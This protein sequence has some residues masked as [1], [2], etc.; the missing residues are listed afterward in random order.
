LLVAIAKSASYKSLHWGIC[1]SERSEESRISNYLRPFASL[2]VTQKS[3]FARGSKAF[4][5]RMVGDIACY[6]L[7]P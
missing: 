1:H 4:S 2:R 3:S 6:A 5:D 7:N